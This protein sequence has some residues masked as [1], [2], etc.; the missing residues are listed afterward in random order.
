[1]WQFLLLWIYLRN[2]DLTN[3]NDLRYY[4]CTMNTHDC[5]TELRNTSLK[6]TTARLAVLKILE[7][8]DKPL[9]ALSLTSSLRQ[10]GGKADPATIFRMMNTFVRQGL[11]KQISFQDKKA[12]YEIATRKDH[13]H[14][15]CEKCGIV[16]DISDC[17]IDVVTH[18]IEKK[19]LLIKSHSLEFFGLC[20]QCQ[21]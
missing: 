15:V 1:M 11:V 3:A 21:L 12:R 14:F 2:K 8:S 20:T 16:E 7:K 6:V 9:S 19:G 10:K 4:E 17:S 18:K 13:H 5:K